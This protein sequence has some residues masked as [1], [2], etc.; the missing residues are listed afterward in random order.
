MAKEYPMLHYTI[1]D[2]L[3]SNTIYDIYQDPNG[4]IWIGTDKGVSRFN[5]LKFEN[6]TTADG[7]SDNECFFFQP[8]YEG[9]LWIGTY[10][11][12]LCYYQ[13]GIF[14]NENNT[15]WLKLPITKSHTSIIRVNKDSSLTFYFRDDPSIFCFKNK[16]LSKYE[17]E[18]IKNKYLNNQTTK[19]SRFFN[20]EKKEEHVYLFTYS[21]E[22]ILFDF[23]QNKILKRTPNK[24]SIV[25]YIPNKGRNYYITENGEIIKDNEHFE[26]IKG[27]N[28]D[29]IKHCTIYS[30]LEA[31]NTNYISTNKGLFINEDH[32]VISSFAVNKTMIDSYNRLW[33]GTAQKGL[34]I[35]PKDFKNTNLLVRNNSSL[36]SFAK[37]QEN[38][39]IVSTNLR[40]YY[41]YDIE[42]NHENVIFNYASHNKLKSELN[43]LQWIFGNSLYS[44]S[45]KENYRISDFLNPKKIKVNRLNVGNLYGASAIQQND[46]YLYLRNRRVLF[47]SKKNEFYYKPNSTLTH[48]VFADDTK[49]IIYGLAQNQEKEIWF[50][51]I[52]SVYKIKD[53][54]PFKQ[55][56]FKNIAFREFVF[57]NQYLLG[58][59]HQNQLIICHNYNQKKITIDSVSAN[60]CVWDKFYTLNDSTLLISTNN[61]FRTISLKPSKNKAIYQLR[62]IE[63]PFIPYQ[64]DYVY[65]DDT[66][67]YFFKKN[68]IKTFP[69]SYVLHQKPLP[70]IQY[71]YLKTGK[72]KFYIK[73]SLILEYDQSKNL[74][75]LFSPISFYHQ[76][77]SYEYSIAKNN[78]VEK[79]NS[80]IGEELNLIDIGF[81]KFII[82]V[83]IKTLSAD[84]SKPATFV[85]LIN[86]PF[87]ATWWFIG[88]CCL[89]FI[90]LAAGIAR[91]VVKGKLKKKEG[92]V[93]FIRSEYKAMNAL[94]NPH[95]IF[96]SLN[97]VQ[98]LVNNNEN[99][100]ASRYLRIFSDLIRQNMRNIAHELIPISKE[101]ELVENYLKIEKLRFKEKLNFS[102]Q[103]EDALETELIQVP[104]LLIQ[105]LVENAIKHG[106]WP[107][108]TS[109][110]FIEIKLFEKENILHI[111]ISDNGNGINANSPSDTMHESYAMS[112]IYT[113]IEQLSKMHQTKIEC[114]IAEIKNENGLILGV[115]S[116][117]IIHLQYH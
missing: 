115:K 57:S 112:N 77:L 65:A 28:K 23:K 68:E 105:P 22:T 75:V 73:D 8:D 35:A 97:S 42:T 111:E 48:R 71:S 13:D 37:K 82:K 108:K 89:L 17:H 95:F 7:L 31:A 47:V 39:L 87:W 66:D 49:S 27:T 51:T 83:R 102:I 109:D 56:Q 38:K 114:H 33:I 53:T 117:I 94:M 88:T 32:D 20:A 54:I 90:A 113:R 78:E 70:T 104:P 43:S 55:V 19:S 107:K 50:S 79:W 98:S 36:V 4:M 60:N 30:I 99:Q 110:G 101:L 85:L 2:G 25:D 81:G 40:D 96:N 59:T 93:R 44:I 29:S 14:H 16:K 84:L 106:I 69:L 72:D 46:N 9:R 3:A 6:F 41:T 24:Q 15:P 58:I 5:G 91:M 67:I 34:Y 10:N 18:I 63:N 1:E 103:I 76:K 80:F 21:D 52:N 74:K 64:P 116:E 61:F 86:K 26:K 92:E 62:V 11:G 45:F 12:K 100:I